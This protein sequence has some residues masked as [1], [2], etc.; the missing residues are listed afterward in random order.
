MMVKRFLYSLV[1][2]F[3]FSFA[4]LKAIPVGPLPDAVFDRNIHTVQFQKEG[5]DFS[6]PILELN[7]ERPLV[8]SFDELDEK[9][10]NYNYSVVFCDADW[11]PSR[12]SYIEYMNGFFQNSLYQYQS[13]FNT[14]VP[15]RHYEIK[16]PNENIS[17]KLSGNYV[18]MVYEGSNDNEPVLMKRFVVVDSRV[19]IKANVRR[20]VLPAYQNR[21]QEVDFTILHPDYAI[22]NPHQ[23]VQA[24][25]IKNNQW[26]NS[27]I[28]LKPLFIRDFELDY[29]YQDKNLFPGGNEYRSFDTKSLKYQQANVKSIDIKN[30]RYEVELLPDKKRTRLPYL[31]QYDL[32]GQF[33]VRNQQGQNPAVDA[34]YVWVKFSLLSFEEIPDG[35]VYVVGGFTDNNCYDDNK[36]VYDSEKGAYELSIPVK[37]GYFNYQYVFQD[38]KGNMDE[39]LLEG[40]YYETGNDYVIYFYHRPYGQR[41]DS[42]IG[43]KIVNS[44]NT[45][46][47]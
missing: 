47:N 33:L 45:I 13:S 15:Y 40:C 20:P 11:M 30:N 46:N 25:I 21:F 28:G 9:D 22:D 26:N 8:L 12:L 17:L 18:L 39:Q 4:G 27:I 19:I 7:D 34:E 43:V 1:A 10:K 29:N 44:V 42:L 37:Q 24:V 5:I 35:N 16:V 32:N 23:S 36:M 6:Y 31:S 14:L 3:I 38:N 2:S 41:Y